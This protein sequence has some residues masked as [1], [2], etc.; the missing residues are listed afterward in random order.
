MTHSVILSEAKNLAIS[1]RSFG[2]RPQD[3]N[4]VINF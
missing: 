4:K 1:M 2:Q 3:D